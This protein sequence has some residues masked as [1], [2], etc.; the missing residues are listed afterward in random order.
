MKTNFNLI[1]LLLIL[2]CGIHFT[3]RSQSDNL[4]PQNN[5]PTLNFSNCNGNWTNYTIP[6]SFN[7]DNNSNVST[8]LGCMTSGNNK[9]DGWFKFTA[10]STSTTI[11]AT[12]NGTRDVGLVVYS[13]SCG[14]MNNLACVN[15]FGQGGT[16][17][18]TLTTAIGT[19][20][21]I[22]I[23]RYQT[24]GSTNNTMDG[25][26]TVRNSAANNDCA[27]ATSLTP[28]TV[29][30]SCSPICGTTLGATSSSP[31]TG[32]SGTAN[33]DV[34]YSFTATQALHVIT[35]VG[36]SNFDPVIELL[37]GPCGSLV[38]RSCADLTGNGGTETITY[39]NFIPGA[40]YFIRVY[41]SDNDIPESTDFT[42]CVTTPVM[43]TCPGSLG[44]GVVNVAALPYSSSGRSTTGKVNDI[45][46]SNAIVCG[47]SNY[48]QGLDEV[49]VFTPAASGS[50]SITL[51]SGSTNVGI[52]LYDGCPFIGQGG[53]CV[54]Y[55][56]SSSGNQ[57]I[58]A[59][60]V[61]GHTYYLIVDRNSANGIT[62]YSISI[63]APISGGIPGSTCANAINISLPYTITGQS[64]L[65]KGNDYN[66][67][68]TGS[69]L[70]LY[71][72]GEDMV[73][74]YTAAAA[75]CISITLSNTS[76]TAAG[77]QLYQNCP[78]SV[79]A[80]CLG[81]IGGGNVNGNFSLPSAGS[82]YIIVDSW[83]PPSAVSFDLSVSL[84]GM[85]VPND[86]P[87]N[88]TVLPLNT[89][90]NGDNSCSGGSS[91]PGAP[92]CWTGGA[93]NTV[94]YAVTP[95]TNTL[96]V[97]TF[98]GTLSN[99][100]IALYQG[101]CASLTQ[102][103][104]TSS[105][106]NQDI[107]CGSNSSNN[108]EITV[109]GL[110]PGN[111]YYVRVDGEQDMTGT[112][113]IMA[114]DGPESNLPP[115]YGQDCST[116]ISVC[117]NS[118]SVA[119]PGFA[120][121]G[122]TC[123]FGS[124]V[125]C[126]SSGE[127]ASA[128]YYIPIGSNGTLEFDIV[129]N[130]WL[131]APSTTSTDYDFAIWEVGQSGITCSQLGSN[132]P[133]RCNYSAYGVTGVSG[134]GNSPGAYPGFNTSYES[135]INV[136][137]GQAYLLL[138]SNYTNSTSG[139]TLNFTSVPDPINYSA[140]PTSMTW[141]GS[142][143]TNYNIAA[144]WGTCVPPSCASD[145]LV[146]PASINQPVIQVNST[147][148][149]LTI[150]PGASLTVNPNIVLSVCGDFTNNGS[151]IML[152][153][154]IIRFV[155]TGT[156]QISGSL[157]GA[158]H[159]ANFTMAK[160]SGTLILQNDIDIFENDSLKTGFFD[161]NAMHIRI[162]KNFY[163]ALGDVTHISPASGSTY[164]FNGTGAQSW[165]NLVEN[166]ILGDVIMNQSPA[167]TLALAAGPYNDLILEGTLTL[168][169][170]KIVTGGSRIVYQLNTAN[171]S[172]SAGNNTSYVEGKLTRSLNG[173]ATGVFDF[174]VGNAAKGY[175]LASI[176][177]T[178]PTQIPEI[179]ATFNSWGAVPNGPVA[180]ECVTA[181]YAT[182]QALNNGYWTL[183]ALANSNTG[184][185][186]ITLHNANYTNMA[187]PGG[188]TVM[189]RSPAGSN[190]W[191]LNGACVLTSTVGATQ[192]TGMDE[193]GDFA[194]AQSSS[195]LPIHLLSFDANVTKEGVMTSWVTATEINN[196][197]FV[198]ERSHNGIEF[199][200][201]DIV[202]GAGN[203]SVSL[204]YSLLDKNP[205]IGIVYYRL[206]QV[207]YDGKFSYS[208]VVAVKIK[209]N[210]TGV[211]I[212]PNPA[213]QSIQVQF[214]SFGISST[215]QVLDIVGKEV[216]HKEVSGKTGLQISEIEIKDLPAGAYSVVITDGIQNQKGW[217]VKKD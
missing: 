189:R 148:N 45:T 49:F 79:G 55:S 128:Y 135:A 63:T 195:P 3:A 126:L 156:Q 42:I 184:T 161:P 140:A 53:S 142:S 109:S 168:T 62:N 121:Y 72:S 50:I 91:E 20:Y 158:N 179:E 174:P 114:V 207:D 112:F 93:L 86:L 188:F 157:T 136:T 44:T 29:G 94:W 129:P 206:K 48:Y 138:V 101:S 203:S 209:N 96:T 105:S 159:F 73:F 164:E 46:A 124:G 162:K 165:V 69:C 204:S 170:G 122:T 196:D 98:L 139:F 192:R 43:P 31:A 28:S 92:S 166:I 35:V 99:T 118:V 22:R 7:V 116:P 216:I 85:G 38:S 171:N 160:P 19:T 155:G 39:S 80:N 10:T 199:S 110:T 75:Q 68:S 115:T 182:N 11:A 26:I 67:G 33:D 2:F 65:C 123:E 211:S 88:A 87:C 13:G 17:S 210:L 194:T 173:F 24:N 104:P 90:I 132:P 120:A 175:Q 57:F 183:N 47:N 40:T 154:S 74:A 41:D 134:T 202:E 12:V 178:S 176:D 113:G 117:S 84:T 149:S 119:N 81:Y 8:N 212:F 137:A 125:N 36:S 103:A 186:D 205:G 82:Y 108:S 16:E 89:N 76:S 1:L 180:S 102:V 169:S 106:C 167:G 200:K 217:F 30:G 100:Q 14:S 6:Q 127:R 78:G 133:V 52:M 208:D 163:N 4:C 153:G 141:T 21:Y 193:F 201:V 215:L 59:N 107:S 190:P 143:N 51:T 130:D 83:D 18:V 37:S 32:C 25:T 197:Y 58:C 172:V 70:S 15:N 56:Q 34:W 95:T 150:A 64:T 185:Y 181:N 146:T 213:S 77:F 5:V 27:T 71:E 23:V 144:N 187:A 97:K 198:V 131:G 151:L 147:V 9:R 66:N 54:D 111:T 61:T 60:V 191:V 145:A 214:E 177:F 152:P